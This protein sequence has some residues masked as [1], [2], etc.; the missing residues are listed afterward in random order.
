MT[1]R[2]GFVGCGGMGKHHLRILQELD[3]FDVVAL[4]DVS[5]DALA[6]C[7][8]EFGVT[9]HFS[10][11]GQM[12]DAAKPDLVVVAT[13]TRHHHGPSLA[14]LERGIHVLCEKP[15]A[16]NPVEAD[17]MV[18]AAAASGANL[19]INQQN[20]VNPA[21]TRAREMIDAGDIGD[22]VLVRG[23]NKHGRK[24]GNEFT[25][26]G[27][28][29]TDI[30]LVVGGMP[31]WVAGTVTWEG[32]HVTPNDIMEAQQMSPKDRDSGPV[33]GERAIAH[34]GFEAGHLG[35]IHFLGYETLDN[36]NY[37]VDVLGSE[38]QLAIRVSGETMGGL[39]HLPRPM[40]GTPAD[41]GDWAAVDLGESAQGKTVATIYQAVAAAIAGAGPVPASG[42]HGRMAME[43]VLGIYASHKAGGQRVELP[44]A[45]RR[46]PLDAWRAEG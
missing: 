24:S 25:E 38:G 20:H 6:A 10:D 27:T 33:A 37:G 18:A 13:Q 34:Y 19:S 14:A 17:D 4:S 12:C 7:G 26:M 40:E 23:R 45:D 8:E 16:I 15:M 30:M 9:E 1:L 43:M 22:V 21:V 31:T 41:L 5:A 3:Q 2:I 44:L 11:C 39:W 28:H 36:T 35:E 46:H 29:V 32:R 42:E